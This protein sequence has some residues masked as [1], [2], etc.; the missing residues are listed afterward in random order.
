MNLL[1]DVFR[2]LFER[3]EGGFDLAFPAEWNPFRQLGALG[4]FF[5]WIVAASGIYL[6][7]FFDTGLTRAYESIEWIMNNQW[8]VG[9][10]MRSLHRYAS[11]ALVVVVVLH[12]SR[13][14]S[15]DRMRGT[16]WFAWF[17]GIPLLWF[18]Y[19]CGISGYW[20]VW[21]VLAQ[22]IAIAT[23]E[24]LDT[25][26]I[27]G[28]LIAANFVNST[29]LSG[30]F[31]TLMVFIHIAVPL[32]MLFLMWVH[33]QR[34]A[35]P[36]MNPPRGLAA[37]TLAALV[38][39][40]LVFP[41]VSQAPADLDTVPAVIGFDW[42]YLAV[43][44]L[45]DVLPGGQLWLGLAI[46]TLIL[47]LLPWAPPLRKPAPAAVDLD[48]CNGCG[49]CAD[50]CPFDA[51][52]MGPRTDGAAY[53]TEAV[54]NTGTC[55]SCGICAGACPTATPHRRATDLMPGIQLPGFPIAELRDQTRATGGKLSGDDRVMV[56]GCEQSRDLAE[57]SAPGVGVVVL[58]CVGM[59]PP[60]FI[61]W[62]LA[63]DLADGVLVSGC[64]GGDCYQR[65][66]DDWTRQRVAR[67]R[68]PY[69]RAR[70]PDERV[71]LC[72]TRSGETTR[73]QRTL[74]ALRSGLATAP[75]LKR[76]AQRAS[77]AETAGG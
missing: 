5:Y 31:F 27:F 55:V 38:I 17:T 61:D 44:P 37:G 24:W 19:A 26:P 51:I 13:E 18:L 72:W 25:L 40:S 47:A 71:G 29:A 45:L 75:Q 62:V 76:R 52:T 14:F 8:Y 32:I 10:V 56:F 6:Y 43:Y 67:Q 7:I 2:R 48:N 57:L 36:R 33:I 9:Q 41:A 15:L 58:P 39:L 4:W 65:L 23:T 77:A 12:L 3:V 21:D 66:G 20:L 54:V 42:F 69:L 16:R 1:K 34:Y 11:D 59:L 28:E 30:R 74:D 50:D 35:R 60:S 22:Y 73:R 53:D 68:D 64:A 46:G 70:V 49:R 63:R